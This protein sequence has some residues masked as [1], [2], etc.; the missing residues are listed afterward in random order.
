LSASALLCIS[1][2]HVPTAVCDE[3]ARHFAPEE[4]AHL[5]WQIAA[6]NLEP[7]RDHN[8]TDRRRLPAVT[9]PCRHRSARNRYRGRT[10]VVRW[11]MIQS[12]PGNGDDVHAQPWQEI[13]HVLRVALP[14]GIGQ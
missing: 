10:T 9:R 7:D 6:I 14:P 4:L 5:I 3:A 13:D 11:C 8:T 12:Y 1:D 2:T